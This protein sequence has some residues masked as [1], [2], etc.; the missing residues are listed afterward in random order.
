MSATTS[1]RGVVRVEHIMGMPI[2]VDVRDV[3]DEAA[4]E[5]VFDWF[6]E[7]DARFSTYKDD[8]EISLLNRG[9]TRVDLTATEFSLLR[10]FTRRPRPSLRPRRRP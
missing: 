10:F 3:D 6:R 1:Q 5:P 4:L 9:E 8:S 2:V 7:V